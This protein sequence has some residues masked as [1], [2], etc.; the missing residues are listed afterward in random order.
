MIRTAWMWA[1]RS[2]ARSGRYAGLALARH[3][4]RRRR[5]GARRRR[6]F[7][8][9]AVRSIPLSSEAVR[10]QRLGEADLSRRVAAILPSLKT[11]I[12]KR[13]DLIKGF[14]VRPI[15]QMREM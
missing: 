2:R 6:D 10:R 1:T 5:S 11:E 15:H 13:S 9:D 12:V 7:V 14:I 4:R 3:R 8:D